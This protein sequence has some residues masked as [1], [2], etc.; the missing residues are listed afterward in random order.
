MITQDQLEEQI[1][2]L[3]DGATLERVLDSL[4]NV[5]IAKAEHLRT[6]W[7]DERA[8]Q[9]WTTAY[10]CVERCRVNTMILGF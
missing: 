9:D 8:A 7:Q 6:N 5:C 1:E 2:H 3:L 4:G 10:K